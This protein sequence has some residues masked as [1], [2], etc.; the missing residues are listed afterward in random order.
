MHWMTHFV[1]PAASPDS[2]LRWMAFW[3]E[4]EQKMGERPELEQQASTLAAP[5]VR[6][7]I[8]G[9]LSAVVIPAIVDQ[10][11]R[12][13]A[14]GELSV[15]PAFDGDQ[16]VLERGL[17]YVAKRGAFLTPEICRAMDVE[18]LEPKLAELRNR[19]LE[20]LRHQLQG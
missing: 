4:I 15:E 11:R 9:Y 7:E 18:P 1:L 20:S 13:T 17:D 10:A 2:Y 19:V 5:F 12:A 14:A 8:A 6:D 3:R 16:E